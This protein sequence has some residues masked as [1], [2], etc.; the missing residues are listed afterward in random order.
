MSVAVDTTCDAILG[1][2]LRMRQPKRGY[3]I[4]ID[5]IMLAAAVPARAGQQVLDVGCGV[6]TAGLVLVRRVAGL[7]VVGLEL[8]RVLADLA[9]DNVRSNDMADSVD[10]VTGDLLCPP[11]CFALTRFDHIMANP[12]YLK[13]GEATSPTDPVAACAVVEGRAGLADWCRF[14]ACM[15][16]PR[17][18]MT[19][20]HRADRAAE[21]VRTFN[22]TGFADLRVCPLWPDAASVVGEPSRDAR[23]VIVS[24]VFGGD[25]PERWL[26]GLV[27][28][29]A[30]GGFRDETEAILRHAAALDLETG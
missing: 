23:R 21:L 24:G 25:G 18:R 9:R 6:G 1:G 27:L 15:L 16:R 12:P 29:D 20:I 10:I 7:R 30:G 8:Q 11:P 19:L 22:D 4:A 2:R 26:D 3:R 17:G 28:H 5:P 13:A 14:G